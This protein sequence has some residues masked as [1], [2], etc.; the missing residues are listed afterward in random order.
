MAENTINSITDIGIVEILDRYGE[1]S[2][3]F[4]YGSSLFV[5]DQYVSFDH[6]MCAKLSSSVG[7]VPY[8][9]TTYISKTPPNFVIVEQMSF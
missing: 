1:I 5:N 3:A 7:N 2:I 4:D 6:S 8:E 9:I